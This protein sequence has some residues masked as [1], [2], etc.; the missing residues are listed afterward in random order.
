MI[1]VDID[2]WRVVVPVGDYREW[3]ARSFQEVHM[4]NHHNPVS[5]DRHSL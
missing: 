2:E 1:F 5:S 4:I 3:I